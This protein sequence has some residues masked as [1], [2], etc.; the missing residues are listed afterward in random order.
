MTDKPLNLRQLVHQALKKES[1][2]AAGQN[3]AL[4]A[5]RFGIFLQASLENLGI[6]AEEMARRLALDPE[7]A[8][9]ILE[10][11]LPSAEMDDDLIR[12][13]AK[14]LQHPAP[15][16]GLLLGRDIPEANETG[17]EARRKP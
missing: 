8:K 16:L 6:N 4:K 9:G 10:G 5:R 13:I 11:M 15:T 3:D 12:E 2:Q 7:L 17:R 14:L 1:Q